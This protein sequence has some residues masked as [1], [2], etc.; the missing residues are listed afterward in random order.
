MS[1][2]SPVL[3]AHPPSLIITEAAFLP[4]LLELIYDSNESEHHTIVVVG[5]VA[6]AN[7]PQVQNVKILHWDEIEHQGAS[8]DKPAL[9]VPGEL[10][11]LYLSSPG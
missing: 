9:P 10:Y 5:D 2:L 11:V 1:L 7:L 6:T 4:H 8:L 3:E